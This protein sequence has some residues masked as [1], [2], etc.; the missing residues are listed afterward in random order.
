[1]TSIPFWDDLQRNINDIYVQKRIQ[2]ISVYL[3]QESYDIN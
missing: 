3:K 1:M 2:K